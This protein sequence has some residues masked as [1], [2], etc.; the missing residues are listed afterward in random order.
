M[1]DLRKINESEPMVRFSSDG[2]TLLQFVDKNFKGS[3]VI[4]NTVK[5]I[6]DYAFYNCIGL[7]NITIP[8]SVTVI[9][10]GAFALCPILSINYLGTRAQW[11]SIRKLNMRKYNVIFNENKES[12]NMLDLRKTIES[13]K[14]EDDKEI[15]FINKGDEFKSDKADAVKII[16]INKKDDKTEVTYKVGDDEKKDDI[17][18]VL[19]MLNGAEYKKV[20]DKKDEKK[21]C[22]SEDDEDGAED[23]ADAGEQT[24]E[25]KAKKEADNKDDNDD[26]E[27]DDKKDES[28]DDGSVEITITEEFHVPGTDIVFE[29]GDVIRIIPKH[30]SIKADG[31]TILTIK[32][33]IVLCEVDTPEFEDYIEFAADD[34]NKS[35]ND[36][37]NL[38]KKLGCFKRIDGDNMFVLPKGM[39]VRVEDLGNTY[40]VYPVDLDPAGFD[41]YDVEE[42]F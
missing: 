28:A 5:T 37:K 36:T 11:N 16:G 4:P 33:D 25:K 31:K 1:I 30:E 19:K 18:D 2:K 10:R 12:N 15:K 20:D 14:N 7:T 22:K 17:E 27:D 6:A 39:K 29:A 38:L 35:E 42:Y 41:A 21:G 40:T 34:L 23:G 24:D 3:Y 26:S 9:G 32:S 8:D 13:K